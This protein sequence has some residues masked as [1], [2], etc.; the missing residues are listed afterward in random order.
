VSGDDDVWWTSPIDH[1]QHSAKIGPRPNDCAVCGLAAENERLQAEVDK[2]SDLAWKASSD[3]DR[4]RAVAWGSAHAIEA[5][6]SDELAD[7][8]PPSSIILRTV[9]RRLWKETSGLDISEPMGSEAEAWTKLDAIGPVEPTPMT[10]EDLAEWAAAEVAQGPGISPDLPTR[11]MGGLPPHHVAPGEGIEGYL[12]RTADENDPANWAFEWPSREWPADGDRAAAI[13]RVHQN[14][15]RDERDAA[16][17]EDIARRAL[18]ATEGDDE[19]QGEDVQAGLL[20]GPE[21]VAATVVADD[22]PT[23]E[24]GPPGGPGTGPAE[25]PP[26]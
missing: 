4:L 23:V 25:P 11:P 19:Q 14:K 7:L 18:E 3:A 8:R 22:A 17:V 24:G 5:V 10:S 6:L 26:L 13:E 21:V 9:A 1:H 20:P 12:R 15:A 2:W 16:A